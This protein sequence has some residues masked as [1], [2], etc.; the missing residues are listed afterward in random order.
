MDNATSSRLNTMQMAGIGA[1]AIGILIGLVG[2]FTNADRF[3]QI[4]LVSFQLWTDMTLG[5]LGFFL[6]LHQVDGKW[7]FVTQRVFAA[8]ARVMPLMA[9]L[10]VPL[11]FRLPQ[12]Y[13]WAGPEEIGGGGYVIYHSVGF[14]AAR[15][16]LY[17]AVWSALAYALSNSS[18]DSD[19]ESEEA[20]AKRY[21]GMQRLAA[22]GI[23]L[24]FI[25]VTFASFDWIMSLETEWFSTVFGWLFV[26]R[27]GMLALTLALIVVTV[28]ANDRSIAKLLTNRVHL[29]LSTLMLVTLMAWLYL[30]VIQYFIMWSGNQPSKIKW[31]VPRT[32]GEWEPFVVFFA[33]AHAVPLLL[34]LTPGLKKYRGLMLAIAGWLIFLRG[35]ELFWMVVP[36]YT[37]EFSVSLWDIALPVGFGGVW[38]AAFAYNYR[39]QPLVPDNHPHLKEMLAHET[40]EHLEG[41]S[42]A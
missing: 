38:L 27:Q 5:C 16:I 1:G 41:A 39:A 12:L 15:V 4:Y 10:F 35:A 29:D 19:G 37:S 14:F 13:A 26:A 31:F 23:V 36:H 7:G 21:P 17:F 6:L 34:L 22:G 33:I 25:T 20:A 24:Y 40:P 28:I 18:Y 11:V 8:G 9:L 3:W 42:T 32:T 30:T 2:A